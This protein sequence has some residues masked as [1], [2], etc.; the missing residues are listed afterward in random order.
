MSDDIEN[1]PLVNLRSEDPRQRSVTLRGLGIRPSGDPRVLSVL[2]ELL[3]DRTA[4][5]VNIPLEYGE[6]RFLAAMALAMERYKQGISEHVCA[7]GTILPLT[8]SS[9]HRIADAA[10]VP[11]ADG[12]WQVLFERL[13]ERGLLPT[14]DID[15]PP[16]VVG[17]L[18]E[19]EQDLPTGGPR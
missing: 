11:S 7:P 2:E 12:G 3:D 1:W 10:A 16:E 6:I 15:W 14:E 8:V 13:R 18:A 4:C 19:N 9:M 5:I 17:K